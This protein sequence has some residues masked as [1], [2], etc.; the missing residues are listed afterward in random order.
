MD[1]LQ[2]GMQHRYILGPK[3]AGMWL[4]FKWKWNRHIR[5]TGGLSGGIRTSDNQMWTP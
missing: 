3:T 1:I 4:I 2:D 5:D